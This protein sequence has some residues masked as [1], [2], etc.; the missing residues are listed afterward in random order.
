MGIDILNLV[1]QVERRFSIEIQ[2]R[3][4]QSMS[5]VGELHDFILSRVPIA[6]AGT[7]LQAAAFVELESGVRTCGFENR[8]G[9]S[10]ELATVLPKT[11]RRQTWRRL[12]SA[13]DLK[14]PDLVKPAIVF[15]A[16]VVVASLL[17]FTIMLYLAG[18][19]AS[20][21]MILGI[22][23]PALTFSLW[24][25][26]VVTRPFEREFGSEL[27][28]FRDLSERILVLNAKELSGRH[29]DMGKNDTWIVLKSI[30]MDVLGVEDQE[31]TRNADIYKDLGC[32]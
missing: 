17:S 32:S 26:S 27:R 3:D 12:S 9:P 19:N 29:G 24:L 16:Y 14:L 15:V 6:P 1:T 20:V 28:T 4:I 8:F 7:C 31:I 13:I 25:G 22:Y 30:L 11:N 2:D 23:F 5:T 21:A 18:D 10:T